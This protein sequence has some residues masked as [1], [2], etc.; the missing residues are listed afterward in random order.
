MHV[1]LLVSPALAG[2]LRGETP[3]AP[4]ADVVRR[5]VHEARAALR[6]TFVDTRDP[7]LRTWFAMDLP[8]DEDP[9]P[10]LRG[11]R[12]LPDVSAAYVKPPAELPG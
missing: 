10:L 2:A 6:P 12:S 5:L 9:E 1:V 11:L 8:D 3:S 7:T 4:G